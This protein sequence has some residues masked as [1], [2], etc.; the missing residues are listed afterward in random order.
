[1]KQ[2]GRTIIAIGVGNATALKELENIASTTAENKSLVYQVGDYK[3]LKTLNSVVA[4][5]ACQGDYK[6]LLP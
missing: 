6:T 4:H 3:A 2:D 1:M 5:V